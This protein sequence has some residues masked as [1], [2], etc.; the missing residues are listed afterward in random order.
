MQKLA[1]IVLIVGSL[2]FIIA[3]F[4]PITIK[5][6]TASDAQKRAEFIMNEHTGWLLV[7]I[8]FGAGGVIAVIG[9]ALF[10][11]H[12]QSV[13]DSPG[14]KLGGYVATAAAGLAAL[15]WVI[16]VYNRAVLPAQ[17]IASNLSINA[18]MFP[19]YT[20]LTQLA[21]IIVGFVLL[22]SGYPAWLGWGMLVLAALSLVAFLVFKDMPPFVHYV[23]LLIMGI[24]LVR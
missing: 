16:I 20:L 15:F 5:V 11:Q 3:A 18:W 7:N 8:L 6:I 9:L 24:V 14:V 1:G 12:V 21:L 17:V 4:T 2:L 22:Q 23:L 10:A 13:A 19:A